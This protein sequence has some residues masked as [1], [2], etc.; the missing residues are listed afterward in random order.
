MIS[1]QNL[2]QRLNGSKYVVAF[3]VFFMLASCGIFSG[4]P[5]YTYIKTEVE[6]PESKAPIRDTVEL[7]EESFI[8][9]DTIIFEIPPSKDI[10]DP[11]DQDHLPDQ[12]SHFETEYKESY[13]IAVLLPLQFGDFLPDLNHLQGHYS[14]RFL[15]FYAGMMLGL[16]DLS[17]MDV[18]LD[19]HVINTKLSDNQFN[20]IKSEL[21]ALDPDAIIGPFDRDLLKEVEQYGKSEDIMVISPWQSSTKIA[22]KNPGY[23]QLKPDVKRY[24]EAIIRHVDAHFDPS[25]VF[26]VGRP[27]DK[28]EMARLDYLLELHKANIFASEPTVDYQTVYVNQAS[29][30][31]GANAFGQI[32]L[33]PGEE[34]AVIL[35]NWSFRDEQFVYTCLRKLNAEKGLSVVNVFGMPLMMNSELVDYNLFKNLNIHIAVEKFVDGEAP[36]VIEFRQRFLQ[37]YD[38]VATDDAIEGYDLI[39]FVGE[40]LKQ[41]GTKYPYFIQGEKLNYLQTSYNLVPVAE[42]TSVEQEEIDQV[43]YFENRHIEIRKFIFNRFELAP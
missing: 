10:Q 24:Y 14:Y 40:N 32:F 36:E 28:Q 15:N 13:Q 42:S 20:A 43:D 11:D 34:I 29:F 19:I 5:G 31:D 4:R 39:R 18:S 6:I 7:P 16:E 25:R 35:P 26:L 33:S 9:E 21:V 41:Y 17:K 2:L 30:V 3:I 22:S 38:A 23:I 12:T 37:A 1:A 27:S 8:E